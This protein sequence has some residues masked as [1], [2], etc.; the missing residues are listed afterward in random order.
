MKKALALLVLLLCPQVGYCIFGIGDITFDPTNFA[1]NTMT[2]FRSLQSNI[3]EATQIQNQIRGYV[4]QARHLV[5]LPMSY[6]DQITGL[7]QEYNN[8]LNQARGIAYT[9]QNGVRQFE[10]LYETTVNGTMPLM[11]RAQAM[12]QQIRASGAAATQMTAIFD[13]LCAEQATVATLQAASQAAPG[14]LAAQQA[15][16]QL[17]GV[18]AEQNA[19]LQQMQATVGRVQIGYVM[20]QTVAEEQAQQNVN[21]YLQAPEPMP[22]TSRPS[23]GFALPN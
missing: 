9:V 10:Q 7:Y 4:Q 16:N 20:R 12:L 5:S 18:L 3:N 19:S 21:Q 14:T 11:Q 23:K 1:Q 15:T 13:R 22:W 2:A 8:T 17:M 6:V